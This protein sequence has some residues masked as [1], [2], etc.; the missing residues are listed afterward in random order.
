MAFP[1]ITNLLIV[2]STFF[3]GYAAG[4]I[5]FNLAKKEVLEGQKYFFIL[6][7]VVLAIIIIIILTY[8]NSYLFLT[9]P[10]SLI[11]LLLIFSITSTNVEKEQAM[12]IALFI[13]LL[14][15]LY[16]SDKKLVFLLSTFI[17]TYLLFSV[18]V[19]K[20]KERKQIRKN[21]SF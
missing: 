1:L 5:I 2:L 12:Y 17:F 15:S 4:N 13:S 8:T 6:R 3:L 20:G 10:L 11:F 19:L 7:Q 16:L 9:L 18:F 14:L 21:I